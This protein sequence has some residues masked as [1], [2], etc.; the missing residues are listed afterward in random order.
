MNAASPRA[1]ERGGI[2][3]APGDRV[4][5]VYA[6]FDGRIKIVRADAAGHETIVG[7]RAPGDVF[8]EL[9]WLNDRRTRVTSA[10]AIEGGAYLRIDLLDFERLCRTDGTLAA[11]FAQGIVRRLTT[12]EGE[13]AELAGKSVPG[14]LVDLLGRLAAE[15]G[16]EESDGSVRI[17]LPLTQGDLA[18]LIGT[19]R[20]TL[21]KEL[22]VLAEVGLVRVAPRSVSLVRP[23]AFPFVRRRS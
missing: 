7:I 14:R 3:Y 12:A 18:D 21:T 20:E 9:S 16:I 4:D 10:V 8:G 15:H 1:V 23:A 2:V 11:A 17:G 6:V 13:L 5:A 22:S 19:S